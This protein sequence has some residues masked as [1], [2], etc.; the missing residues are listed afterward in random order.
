LT[1][2]I[3]RILQYAGVVEEAGDSSEFKKGD[4]VAVRTGFGPPNAAT[5][6]PKYS[7]HQKYVVAKDE[8][9]SKLGDKTSFQDAAGTNVNLATAVGALSA[10]MGIEKPTAPNNI[11][12][13]LAKKILLYGGSSNVGSLSIQYALRAGLTVITTSSPHNKAFVQSLGPT[14]IIDHTLPNTSLLTAIEAEGPYDYIFDTISLPQ[15]ISL[16]SKYLSTLSG[17]PIYTTQPFFGPQEIPS[18]VELKFFPYPTL[19]ENTELGEW[20]RKVYL[21][22]GL[23]E[24]WFV[25]TRAEIVEGGLD[26]IQGCLDRFAEGRVSGVKMVVEPFGSRV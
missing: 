10:A 6:D 26:G 18:N 24:G 3:S 1:W 9:I 23:D 2:D 16:L 4:R 22:Q 5:W 25:L 19:L 11:N 20:V 17:G 13:S 8:W 12:P 7:S 15:T 14:K 21:P